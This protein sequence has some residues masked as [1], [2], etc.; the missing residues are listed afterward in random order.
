MRPDRSHSPV[1]ALALFGTLHAVWSDVHPVCDQVVQRGR[2]AIRKGE[3]G[4][5]GRAAAAR[6]VASYTVG[7]ILVAELVTRG[8]GYRV[9]GRAML[10]G[11]LIN[12]ATHYV[13]DRRQ[14]LI[15]LMRTRLLDKGGYIDHA[16]VQRRPGVV[17]AAGPGTALFEIDLLCTSASVAGVR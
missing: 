11:H 2:D 4:P 13:I 3:P 10:T 5:A 17:D 8:L 6:H 7:Q 12:A 14:P 15:R 1:R 16:T 9:P